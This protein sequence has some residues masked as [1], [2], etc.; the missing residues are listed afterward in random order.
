MVISAFE[1]NQAGKGQGE[2]GGGSQSQKGRLLP[3]RVDLTKGLE[4]GA[5]FLPPQNP[6]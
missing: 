1:N 4:E 6:P 5:P 3:A 2:A